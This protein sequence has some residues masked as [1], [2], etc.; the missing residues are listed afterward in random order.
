MSNKG[1]PKGKVGVKA[2]E[3]TE[4]KQNKSEAVKEVNRKLTSPELP[5]AMK[6]MLADEKGED[7]SL[8][9]IRVDFYPRGIMEVRFLTESGTEVGSEWMSPAEYDVFKGKFKLAQKAKGEAQAASGLLKKLGTRCLIF[10]KPKDAG[11]AVKFI[12]TKP[13]PKLILGMLSYTQVEFN[14]KYPNPDAILDF[15]VSIQSE[16]DRDELQEYAEKLGENF[17]QTLKD[18]VKEKSARTER[19]AEK[20]KR[21]VEAKAEEKPK[22]GQALTWPEPPTASRNEVIPKAAMQSSKPELSKENFEHLVT[23]YLTSSGKVTQL[24]KSKA[25]VDLTQWVGE[26][27]VEELMSSVEESQLLKRPELPDEHLF[28]VDEI[29][30]FFKEGKDRPQFMH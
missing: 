3:N 29:A 8:R 2:N 22:E 26:D 24:M 4:K 20:A 16:S 10:A 19:K 14:A 25:Y 5:G 9:C 7:S 6:F 12:D 27:L 21:K 30:T 13:V 23:T 18:L 1:N 17:M 11:E 28:F 15:W